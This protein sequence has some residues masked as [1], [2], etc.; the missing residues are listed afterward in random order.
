LDGEAEAVGLCDQLAIDDRDTDG[1]QLA[2]FDSCG[3]RLDDGV[4]TVYEAVADTEI[5]AV[6]E[7]LEE[8]DLDALADCE[9]VAE[10]VGLFDAAAEAELDTDPLDEAADVALARPEGDGLLERDPLGEAVPVREA[11]EDGEA[12]GSAL[13]ERL[14]VAEFVAAGERLSSPEVEGV[15]VPARLAVAVAET[16]PGGAT[17]IQDREGDVVAVVDCFGETDPEREP[18]DE[19]V[20]LI[21]LLG[22]AELELNGD[23]VGE[24]LVERETA[25]DTLCVGEPLVVRETAGDKLCVGD[26]VA[27][28][29]CDGE[30][31]TLHEAR[32]LAVGD[33]EFDGKRM[34]ADWPTSPYV[35]QPSAQDVQLALPNPAANV[36]AGQAVQ[37]ELCA[38]LL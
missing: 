5:D 27:V 26:A 17:K 15:A 35:V 25:G 8:A 24:P 16:E 13:S 1:E 33:G 21:E 3:D 30:A 32:G 37:L 20:L 22:A 34:Q 4:C 9:T 12:V 31:V 38:E 2:L 11:L 19:P 28:L 29:D 23:C 10:M 18:E 6:L 14:T 36:F 7:P